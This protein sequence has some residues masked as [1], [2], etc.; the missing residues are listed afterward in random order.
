MRLERRRGE[1][2]EVVATVAVVRD[3]DGSPTALRW[4][5][6]ET[7][8][9]TPGASIDSRVPSQAS[10]LEVTGGH[11]PRED[12]I[13]FYRNLIRGIDL[14]IWEVDAATGR[15]RFI[16]PRV[17]E[18]LGHSTD[19][20]L[21]DPD[22][23]LKIVHPEDRHTV[24][25]QARA[26]PENGRASRGRVSAPRSRSTEY[27]VSGVDPAGPRRRRKAFVSPGL[28]LE[29]RRSQKGRAR[30]PHRSTTFAGASST[31]CRSC[32]SWRVSS[33]VKCTSTKS[34]ARSFARPR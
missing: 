22:F 6:R 4:L 18:E 20:W 3:W 26:L 16:S 5:F 33:R 34:S 13:A 28:P 30:S 27:L 1:P 7:P 17:E 2:A 14:I 32:R 19:N 15:Y 9:F 31:I 21:N 29:Y 8:D 12:E 11:S 23:W 25:T 24:R 10:E